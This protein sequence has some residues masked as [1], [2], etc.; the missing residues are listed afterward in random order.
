MD[1]LSQAVRLIADIR[2]SADRLLEALF[3]AA[4]PHQSSKP[5]HLFLNEDASMRLH[6]LDLRSV[7]TS[8]LSQAAGRIWSLERVAV[9]TE[10][11][12]GITYVVD[13]SGRRRCCVCLEAAA[14]RPSWSVCCWQ[15]HVGLKFIDYI[16]YLK[17]HD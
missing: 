6:L 4:Q 13:L 8:S 5:L 9:I 1:R 3:L 14:R 15:D 11:F 2:L 12:L 7:V 17:N 16:L 10:Q